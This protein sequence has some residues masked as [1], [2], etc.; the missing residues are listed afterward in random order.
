MEAEEEVYNEVCC[1][2]RVLQCESGF[3]VAVVVAAVA[4]GLGDGSE[5]QYRND[6]ESQADDFGTDR[7]WQKDRL[8]VY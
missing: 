4:F 3:V 6:D 5:D 1:L 8:I 2:V 7:W